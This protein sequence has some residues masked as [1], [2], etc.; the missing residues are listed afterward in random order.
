ML[1]LIMENTWTLG[2]G[3]VEITVM[4]SNSHIIHAANCNSNLMGLT[5]SPLSYLSS[6]D[7][8]SSANFLTIFLQV[9][10][11]KIF[12]LSK[13]VLYLCKNWREFNFW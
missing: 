4:S 7:T 10:F 13:F 6:P 5:K 3:N 11:T 8:F 2:N 1:F 12:Y 9:H